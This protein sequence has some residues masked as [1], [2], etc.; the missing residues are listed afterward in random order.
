MKTLLKLSGWVE[1]AAVI[2]A[3]ILILMAIAGIVLKT[4]I[5]GYADMLS[6]FHTANTFF[7][8]AIVMFL[9]RHFR[10]ESRE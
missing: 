6:F 8:F 10:K 9:F 1:W 2:I 3:V 7:L 5:L 4:P